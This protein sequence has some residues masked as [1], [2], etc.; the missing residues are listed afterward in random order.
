M[1]LIKVTKAAFCVLTQRMYL[2]ERM[3]RG[4][5]LDRDGYGADI[6]RSLSHRAARKQ[7]QRRDGP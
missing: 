7:R 4:T 6:P 1:K 2:G 3:Y 5:P